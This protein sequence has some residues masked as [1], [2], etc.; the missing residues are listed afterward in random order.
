MRELI[1]SL[2]PS[3]L[4]NV[5]LITEQGLELEKLHYS[6]TKDLESLNRINDT[7]LFLSALYIRKL[8]LDGPHCD[9]SD[10]LR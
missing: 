1:E 5:I 9:F 10:R 2:D 4:L 3:R 8:D 6:A 7:C